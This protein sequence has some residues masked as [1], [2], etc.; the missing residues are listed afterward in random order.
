MATP[1][2]RAVQTLRAA[3]AKLNAANPEVCVEGSNGE[4]R[5][6]WHAP[7]ATQRQDVPGRIELWAGLELLQT[8]FRMVSGDPLTGKLDWATNDK[9]AMVEQLVN[10]I[11]EVSGDVGAEL[12]QAKVAWEAATKQN[13]SRRLAG[14]KADRIDRAYDLA[15]RRVEDRDLLAGWLD[16]KGMTK[17]SELSV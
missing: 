9:E 16:G 13:S 5:L 12:A 14:D 3:A 11:Q 10:Y 1:T 15:T 6:V 4:V 7:T 17:G 2:E 8:T